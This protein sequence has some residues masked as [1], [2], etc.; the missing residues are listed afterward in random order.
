MVDSELEK[1]SVTQPTANPSSA[2]RPDREPPPTRPVAVL[3]LGASAVRLLI[4]EMVPGQPPAILEEAQRAVLLGKDAFTGGRLG[5]G[6]IEATLRAL[7]G[8]RQ[9]MDSYGVV[10]YRAVATSAVREAINRDTFLDRVR[11]RTGLNVEVIDGSEE[12]RLTYTAVREALREHEALVVGDALL[13]EVGGGSADLSFLRRGE[14]VHSGTYA[15]G[16]VR[17]RQGLAA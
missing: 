2:S 14:P 12:N 8:F 4:A 17:M 9:I 10:R 6:T 7:D 5:A 15:L 16:A 1:S 13:V 11:L 3:D